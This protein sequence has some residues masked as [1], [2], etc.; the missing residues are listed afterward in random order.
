MNLYK[1]GQEVKFVEEFTIVTLLSETKLTI[2]KGDK[3]IVTRTGFKMLTGEAR[4][5]IINFNKS[6]IVKGYDY[7]NI[8]RLILNRINAVFGLE[9]YLEDE[10]IESSEIIEEIED[11]LMDI[12]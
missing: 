3:A 12:L 9:M 7:E 10:A 2:K 11:V 5:K 4:G 6:D 1:L 8:S